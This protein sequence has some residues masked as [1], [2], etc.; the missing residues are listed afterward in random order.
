MTHERLAI[1]RLSTDLGLPEGDA[2]TQEWAHELPEEF[3]TG[4]YLR[5]YL[6]AYSNPSYGDAER[7]LLVQLALDVIN[8][9][10]EQDE[11]LGLDFWSQLLEVLKGHSQSHRDQMEYWALDD[12]PLED[13]FPLTPLARRFLRANAA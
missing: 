13:A 3:R 4:T 11:S 2:Y 6:K 10:L 8:D 1:S 9:L 7:R 12:E 5:R